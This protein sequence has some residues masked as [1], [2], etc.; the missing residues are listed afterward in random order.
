[1]LFLAGKE[2]LEAMNVDT[3][4][5]RVRAEFEEMPGLTLTVR[6]ASR[7]FGLDQ[8]ICREVVNRLVGADF[9]RWSNAGVVARGDR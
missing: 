8:Q 7:L 9:L 3:V 5:D 6:Q 4:A 2:G 1:L